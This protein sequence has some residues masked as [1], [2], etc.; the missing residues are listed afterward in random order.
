MG[1]L[2]GEDV[3]GGAGLALAEASLGVV[4]G[5]ADTCAWLPMLPVQPLT[6]STISSAVAITWILISSKRRLCS[7]VAIGLPPL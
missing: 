7:L 3:S 5:E 1:T 2:V 6:T 4:V